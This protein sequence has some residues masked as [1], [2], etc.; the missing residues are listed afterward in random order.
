ME[1]FFTSFSLNRHINNINNKYYFTHKIN[2]DFYHVFPDRKS[3]EELY[4]SV[5]SAINKYGNNKTVIYNKKNRQPRKKSL[6]NHAHLMHKGPDK[7]ALMKSIG[8]LKSMGKRR[9]KLQ[10]YKRW[11]NLSGK[12][13]FMHDLDA[14]A[15]STYN[16]ITVINPKKGNVVIKKKLPKVSPIFLEKGNSSINIHSA[17]KKKVKFVPVFNKNLPYYKSVPYNHTAS[18]KAENLTPETQTEGTVTNMNFYNGYFNVT[19]TIL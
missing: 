5:Q 6:Q 18:T 14:A 9:K 15:D 12:F 11:A 16:A 3:E 8:D 2:E 7:W 10:W 13:H 1:P 17:R 19:L 4:H